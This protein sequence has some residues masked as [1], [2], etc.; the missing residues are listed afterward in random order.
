MKTFL[1][2]G[3]LLALSSFAWGEVG[4]SVAGVQVVAK[5]YQEEG[6]KEELR[7]FNWSPGLN[8]ALLLKS[9]DKA[10]VGFDKEKSS[11]SRFGDDKGQDFLKL[12]KRF[13][14]R[15]FSFGMEQESESRKALMTTLESDALPASGATRITLAGELVLSL[16]SKSELKKS[17][18]AAVKK[19]QKLVVAG[20]TFTIK[21]AEKPEWGEGKLEI[22]LE[23]SVDL[24][25]F[26][27][28]VF[29][30]ADGKELESERGMWSSMGMFGKKTYQTSYRFKV[31]P[32]ELV[33]GLD[34][35]TD[36]E[37]VKVPVD[38]KIGV[39]L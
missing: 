25:S 1:L 32:E 10:I 7:A 5:E 24:K 31:K 11:L 17:E 16:A 15:A 39:G 6:S 23:S 28:V 9:D 27:R 2:A 14:D 12:E 37:V 4:V 21:D 38:L 20:E 34:V 3:S 18:K 33:M 22:T 36:L 35:W 13:S 30:G 8:I 29:Y 26:R 19:G